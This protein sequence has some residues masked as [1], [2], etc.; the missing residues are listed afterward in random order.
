M[1]IA[2]LLIRES[3]VDKAQKRSGAMRSQINCH[4]G[5]SAERRRRKPSDLQQRV[6][7]Q[8]KEPAVMGLRLPSKSV[9][10]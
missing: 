9:S 10:K 5:L 1:P 2:R 7:L 4:H 8:L 3:R 6:W